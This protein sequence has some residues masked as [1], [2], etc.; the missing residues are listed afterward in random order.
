MKGIHRFTPNRET[1]PTFGA[2]LREA[3]DVGVRVLALDCITAPDSI[4]ADAF[5]PVIL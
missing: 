4:E 1:D 3:R 2:A 5:V